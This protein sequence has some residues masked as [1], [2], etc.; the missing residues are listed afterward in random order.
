MTTTI[1]IGGKGGTGK[2]TI[3]A[4]LIQLLSQKGVVLAIDGDPSSNLHLAM[5]LPLTDE[6][7]DIREEMLTSIKSGRFET[8]ISKP[9]YIELKIHEALVESNKIDLLAM[10][11]PEGPSCY[12]AANN[13]LRTSIDRLANNYDYVVIDNEAGMEHISR[14]TTRDVDILLIISDPSL[15]GLVTAARI[16]DLIAELRTQVGKIALV[17]NR[18]DGSLSAEGQRLVEQAGLEVIGLLPTDPQVAS[19]DSTGAPLTELDEGS[20]LR[21]GVQDIARKLNLV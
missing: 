11:R 2:T 7:G 13:M 19:L 1:A 18:L 17:I 12:C 15:R 10:G 3:A 20:S 14:Q 4:L 16:K 6:V 21:Q 8:G 9:D 5:G